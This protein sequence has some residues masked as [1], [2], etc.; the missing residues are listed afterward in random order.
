MIF[1]TGKT[2]EVVIYHIHNKYVSDAGV[3]SVLWWI[4]SDHNYTEKFIKPHAV[5]ILLDG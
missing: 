5:E 2:G 1:M 3:A 4:I